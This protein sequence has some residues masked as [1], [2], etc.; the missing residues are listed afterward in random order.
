MTEIV[1]GAV[2]L[3]FAIDELLVGELLLEAVLEGELLLQPVAAAATAQ[4]ASTVAI[5]FSR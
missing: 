5:A 1:T 4:A 2:E 3:A